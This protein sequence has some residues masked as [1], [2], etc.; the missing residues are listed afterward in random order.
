MKRERASVDVDKFVDAVEGPAS[1]RNVV[2]R[3]LGKVAPSINPTGPTIE[4]LEAED[5]RLRLESRI[6][7]RLQLIPRIHNHVRLDSELIPDEVRQWFDD[8]VNGRSDRGLLMTGEPGRGKSGAMWAIYRELVE[9]DH[10]ARVDARKTVTLLRMLMP[11]SGIDANGEIRRLSDVDLLL[12]DDVGAQKG[13]EWKDERLYEILDSRY[14]G[15]LPTVVTT[16]VPPD[17]MSEQLGDRLGSRFKEQAFQLTFFGGPDLRSQLGPRR[18][19]CRRTPRRS[20]SGGITLRLDRHWPGQL[21]IFKKEDQVGFEADTLEFPARP[22]ER[23][24]EARV[25]AEPKCST[26]LS[27]YNRESKCYAHREPSYVLCVTA[28]CYGEAT[29][30]GAKCVGCLEDERSRLAA[31]R[32]QHYEHC[33]CGR[34][35]DRRVAPEGDLCSVCL[36]EERLLAE[37]RSISQVAVG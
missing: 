29:S 7:R 30:K 32:P 8:F 36:V 14:E 25:C 27:I 4:E 5:E 18:V 26:I 21:E 37:V 1:V 31:R 13:T 17:Q 34:V 22:V 12:L 28:G 2:E 11:E 33:R 9:T 24:D 20:D 15:C 35:I 6:A 23:I 10:P 3:I 19:S 16:N